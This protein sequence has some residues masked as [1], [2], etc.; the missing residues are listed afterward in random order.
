MEA[1]PLEVAHAL[2]PLRGC[3][4]TH[5]VTMRAPCWMCYLIHEVI[6]L[7][8]AANGTADV[9]IDV[10]HRHVSA[11][12]YTFQTDWNMPSPH[13][14]LRIRRPAGMSGP[15][16]RLAVIFAK[17]VLTLDAESTAS[18]IH[19]IYIQSLTRLKRQTLSDS[20]PGRHPG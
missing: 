5:S 16:F 3:T 11:I 13:V 2:S 14:A 10:A 15:A 1:K 12:K 9:V 8:L 20:R 4:D 6:G 17:N 18:A 19:T 7:R